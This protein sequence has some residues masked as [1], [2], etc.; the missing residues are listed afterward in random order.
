MRRRR[1][2]AT[3][4][5][6]SGG[7]A[8]TRGRAASL[9]AAGA[10]AVVLARDEH[11][12]RAEAAVGERR[13]VQPR[14]PE[15]RRAQRAARVLAAQLARAPRDVG[16]HLGAE[17]LAARVEVEPGRERRRRARRQRHARHLAVPRE[18][19]SDRPGLR[20]LL[21][22]QLRQLAAVSVR[23]VGPT[24]RLQAQVRRKLVLGHRRGDRRGRAAVGREERLELV[25]AAGRRAASASPPA[26]RAQFRS[27][28]AASDRRGTP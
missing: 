17:R 3:P 14:Q 22:E 23:L 8:R 26:A 19:H 10:L 7:R 1:R 15:Q 28:S 24:R 4:A 25:E 5:R 20:R 11:R 21:P 27:A 9:A 2:R 6:A 16:L 12:R 18:D 13:L